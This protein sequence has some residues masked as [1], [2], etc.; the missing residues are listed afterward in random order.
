MKQSI[1]RGA[2]LSLRGVLEHP[3]HPPPPP[4]PPPGYATDR[5]FS[6]VPSSHLSLFSLRHTKKLC[7]S[8]Y[9]IWSD[10][11]CLRDRIPRS[12]L[13]TN[14][15]KYVRLYMISVSSSKLTFLSLLLLKTHKKIMSV[16][17]LIWPVGPSVLE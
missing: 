17:Y 10:L 13:H 4:P 12:V 14:H 5:H 11:L 6:V 3:E 2:G 1:A 7:E 9:I 16:T 8:M 15:I